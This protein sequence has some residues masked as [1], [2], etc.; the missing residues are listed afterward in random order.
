MKIFRIFLAVL[1]LLM[2]VFVLAIAA[3]YLFIDPNQ[4]KPVISNAVL[5][6]TGYQLSIDDKLKWSLH[7]F[8]VIVHHATL[9]KDKQKVP[10]LDLS[11]MKIAMKLSSLWTSPQRL[12][13][14][15]KIS[16]LRFMKVH[17]QDVDL[18]ITQK[19]D[20]LYLQIIDAKLY[21]G[22]LKGIITGREFSRN[23][24]WRADLDFNQITLQPL[25]YDLS[26]GRSKITVAGNTTVQLHLSTQGDHQTTLLQNLNGTVDYQ[27]LQGALL[28]IDLNYFIQ[29]ADRLVSQ[30]DDSS[31][32]INNTKQTPFSRAYGSAIITNGNADHH[33]F[34]ESASFRA[35]G[36]G[37]LNLIDQTLDDQLEVTPLHTTTL[38]WPVPL[39]VE[40][41]LNDLSIR[42][43][44]L[45]IQTMIT[46]EHLEKITTK[47][48]KEIKKLPEKANQFLNKLFQGE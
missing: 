40:G 17:A 28:G 3:L 20:A 47:V 12:Q 14:D 33:L 26:N 19:N 11:D 23:P 15:I 25:L 27:V 36:S 42:L 22:S 48:Q 32:S 13:S 46:Q 39:L 29:N 44:M 37:N 41:P 6:K 31:T 4:L 8:G 10:F 35:K 43:D 2:I 45:K 1:S 38:K 34:L 7:P 30:K 9:S 18:K 16:K 5:K 24:L 21:E